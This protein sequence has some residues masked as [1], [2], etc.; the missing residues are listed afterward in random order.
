[1]P[2]EWKKRCRRDQTIASDRKIWESRCG[3]YRVVL[4]HIRYGGGVLADYFYAQEFEEPRSW[5]NISHHR[6][7]EPAFRACENRQKQK[8][9]KPKKKLKKNSK[10]SKFTGL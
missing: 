3:L 2:L 8:E 10:S 4:S 1:M 7:K 6:K 5:Q 9:S